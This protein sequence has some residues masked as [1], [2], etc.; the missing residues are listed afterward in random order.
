M[1]QL[2]QFSS[3]EQGVLAQNM[4]AIENCIQLKN[5]RYCNMRMIHMK[6]EEGK[7]LTVRITITAEPTVFD[8][9]VYPDETEVTTCTIEQLKHL[10]KH[11]GEKLQ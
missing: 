7:E 3:F 5:K 10:E 2:P 9:T 11:H 1:T 4:D 8:G 6:D